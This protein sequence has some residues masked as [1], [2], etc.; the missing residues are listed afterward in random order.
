MHTMFAI[1]LLYTVLNFTKFSGFFIVV[2]YFDFS[3]LLQNL[4]I[5]TIIIV[6]HYCYAVDLQHLA[7]RSL[8]F[9]AVSQAST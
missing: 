1:I 7:Y 9:A 8:S 2:L 6:W 3:N 4:S 5:L